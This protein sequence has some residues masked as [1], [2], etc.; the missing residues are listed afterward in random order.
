[1]DGKVVMKL[2]ARQL[3][4][5]IREEVEKVVVAELWAPGAEHHK[6]SREKQKQRSP[7]RTEDLPAALREMLKNLVLA[8]IPFGKLARALQLAKR[9][10]KVAHVKDLSNEMIEKHT[11]CAGLDENTIEWVQDNKGLFPDWWVEFVGD[12]NPWFKGCP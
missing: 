1:M 2:T 7:F 5:I 4:Q 12:T 10:Q 11:A 6:K 9:E 3:R 8:G